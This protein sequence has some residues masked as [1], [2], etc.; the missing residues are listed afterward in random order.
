MFREGAGPGPTFCK[1]KSELEA[2]AAGQD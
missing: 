1:L 2:G